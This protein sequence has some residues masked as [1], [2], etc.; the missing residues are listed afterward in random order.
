MTRLI[1]VQKDV[2][3]AKA[4]VKN[5]K[6]MKAC[7]RLKFIETRRIVSLYRLKRQAIKQLL[8]LINRINVSTK[9]ENPASQK[10]ATDLVLEKADRTIILKSVKEVQHARQIYIHM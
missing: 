5:Y 1:N 3:S 6:V 2:Q 10:V 9:L 4:F 7:T 8:L